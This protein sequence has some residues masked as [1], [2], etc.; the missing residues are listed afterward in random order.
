VGIVDTILGVKVV[1]VEGSLGFAMDGVFEG[2]IVGLRDGNGI[3]DIINEVGDALGETL[4]FKDG[5]IV[6]MTEGGLDGASDG[7]LLG[8]DIE[9]L[10]V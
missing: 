9:E 10:T 8:G 7:A 2:A 3:E 6:G 5:C 1:T 4:G